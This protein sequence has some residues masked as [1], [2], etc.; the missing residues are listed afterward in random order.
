MVGEGVEKEQ[1]HNDVE[2]ASTSA[3]I[4]LVCGLVMVA[5]AQQQPQPAPSPVQLR[6]MSPGVMM[7]QHF[8]PCTMLG[9]QWNQ[10]PL[11]VGNASVFDF[12]EGEGPDT[13]NWMENAQLLGADTV[14]LT[15]RH[16]DGFHLW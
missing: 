10:D 12:P 15:V 9:C 1:T 11:G 2:M 14:C 4:A 13:D 3:V 16:V 8:G 6:G 5:S 7:F